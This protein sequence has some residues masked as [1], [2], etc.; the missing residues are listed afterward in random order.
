MRLVVGSG[1][2]ASMLLTVMREDKET[3]L[4]GRN[5]KTVDY[6]LADFPNVKK[7]N[8]QHFSLIKD[9]FLCLPPDG[10][11]GFILKHKNLFDHNVTFYH[12]ATAFKEEDVQLM[13]GN[14]KVVPLKLAGHAMVVK[15]EKSGLFV[16]G[17]QYK[18][19][20]G[21]IEN[22]FPT[23]NIEIG[24]EA[25]VLLANQLGT[26]AAIKMVYQLKEKLERNAISP[27]IAEH[28]LSQ[29]VQGV[30]KA[31]QNQDLGGFAKKIAQ[32][33]EQKGEKLNEDG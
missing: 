2:L 22:L 29:T 33:L 15:K 11:E 26:E 23:M 7:A 13:V 25:D 31:Y 32:Q 17:E 14:K 28:T 6:L 12:M 8:E 21:K 30:I 4:Y 9:V 10:Y 18:E 3:Y 24:S 19:D 20:L 16:L 1:R 27:K 5:P